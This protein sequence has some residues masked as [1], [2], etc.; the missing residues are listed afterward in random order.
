MDIIDTSCIYIQP[1]Y[2][3]YPKGN[4]HINVF[5]DFT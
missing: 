1:I 2:R 4:T 5:I 3:Q